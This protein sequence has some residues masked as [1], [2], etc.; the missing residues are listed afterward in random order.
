MISNM[1]LEN[2]LQMQPTPYVPLSDKIFIPNKINWGVDTEVLF[3]NLLYD[4]T[5]DPIIDF[6]NPF[7]VLLH[8][9]VK[10]QCLWHLVH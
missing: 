3:R 8:S 1:N 6:T 7:I 4:V 2:D 9:S 5:I 10:I